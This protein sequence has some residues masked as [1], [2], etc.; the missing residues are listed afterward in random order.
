MIIALSGLAGTGKD[1]AADMLVRNHGFVKVALAD[2]LK[3]IC[4]DVFDFTDEQLWGQSESR[5]APDKRYRRRDIVVSHARDCYE[6]GNHYEAPSG[7]RPDGPARC[8][9]CCSVA[10]TN[11][12]DIFREEYLT[13]RHALQQLGTE[14]GRNCY[15]DVW[16]EYAVRVCE[17]LQ[18]GDHYYD[19][20]TGLRTTTS[21]ADVMEPKKNVVISDVRFKNEVARLKR[22][23]AKM[24]R[25][26][27][28]GHDTPKWDHPSET[29]QLEIPDSEFDLIFDNNKTLGELAAAVSMMLSKGLL[30]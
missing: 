9:K 26:V 28:P 15:D 2:P 24:I 14:W 8:P 21:V 1:T 12:S 30:E 18:R 29:E 13:P 10:W 27:R 5:N 19:A 11:G 20:R 22:A 16:V 17:T 23:G 4:R 3:R 7:P 25:I 6:C